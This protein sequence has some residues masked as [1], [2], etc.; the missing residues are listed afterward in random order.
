M[1]AKSTRLSRVGAAAWL[2]EL[3]TPRRYFASQF[4]TA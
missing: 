2:D 4:A 1:V 3:D